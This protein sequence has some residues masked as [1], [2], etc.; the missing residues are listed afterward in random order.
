MSCTCILMYETFVYFYGEEAVGKKA[1]QQVNIEVH[2]PSPGTTSGTCTL[3]LRTTF[4][5]SPE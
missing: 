5:L 2:V 1:V 4:L 3:G